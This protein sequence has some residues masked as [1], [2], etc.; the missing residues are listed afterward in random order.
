MTT[1]GLWRRLE[2]HD[3]GR[4]GL[5]RGIRAALA[6][7]ISVAISLYVVGDPAGAPFA[8]FGAV[9][10][11]MTADYAG[12]LRQRT[13]DYLVT[14]VVVSALIPLG[15]L[16]AG[17]PWT[18]ALATFV[19]AFLA[20]LVAMVR[21]N[22]A[23]G[24]PAALL[25]FIVA[26]TVGDSNTSVSH[27]LIGW[28]IAV[29]VCTVV[30]L[31]VFPRQ[32]E[33]LAKELLA[34][35]LELSSQ[36]VVA[37]CLDPVDEVRI[38][39][40]GSRVD[41]VLVTLK[42]VHA[43]KPFRPSGATREDRALGILLDHAWSMREVIRNPDLS[44]PPT[45]GDGPL[46]DAGRKLA[47]AIADCLHE[48]AVALQDPSSM[49]P[50][51]DSIVVAREAF[52][53]ATTDDV[54]EKS[55]AGTAPRE[56]ASR[57]VERHL[58]G[59]AS[60]ITEQ[61][62]QLVREVNHHRIEAVEG[63][64]SVPQRPLVGFIRSQLTLSSPWLRNALRSATGLAIAM[65][66]VSITTIEDG[67]WVLLGVIAVLR[68]DSFT[69]KRNAWQAL[70]GTAIGVVITSGIIML[71]GRN[72]GVIWVLLVISVFLAGWTAVA[73]NYPV[74]Q[75]AFSGFV[76]LLVATVKWPPQLL[77]G[78][79]RVLDVALGALIAVAVALV[80]WPRGAVGTL[81]AAMRKNV[82]TTWKYLSDVLRAYAE[83]ASAGRLDSDLEEARRAVLVGAE[84]YDIS[85][86]QR[87]PGMPDDSMWVA[88]TADGYL[89]L[90]LARTMAPFTEG[91]APAG[92]S[93]T[94]VAALQQQISAG[95][96]YWHQVADAI[97]AAKPGTVPRLPSAPVWSEVRDP[98]TTRPQAEGFVA[99]V[100][101][102]DWIQRIYQVGSVTRQASDDSVA[103]L[104]VDA[105]S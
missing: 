48:T 77:T 44:K 103:R 54:L 68:F 34:E 35:V 105:S 13:V 32:R 28:W 100:W 89:M 99:T 6:L 5:R 49:L 41:S 73:W 16:V 50:T 75:A 20:A 95:N 91:Q 3:P 18:A 92:W 39:A 98:I 57:I 7:P 14:G 4:I 29:V 47:R 70:L 27:A 56:L 22:L 88:L 83:P 97:Q 51:V 81:N 19:V 65:F 85:L 96:D 23:V 71:L 46:P 55:Q 61:T 101:L 43:G 102:L 84:T 37:S 82:L 94:L 10:L 86:M 79:F 59:M 67:F 36:M 9:G 24:A 1:A 78:E 25:M 30:A 104:S 38:K 58:L 93:P 33:Q 62:A 31:L 69:T 90:N 74:A 2:A 60:V 15:W 53:S 12:S 64:L 40:L 17:N 21:G 42:G 63:A 80:M 8:G 76:L 26:A 87:G 45:L 52:R 72:L 11:L 66:V